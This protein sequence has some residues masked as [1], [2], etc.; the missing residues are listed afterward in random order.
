MGLREYKRELKKISGQLGMALKKLHKGF[1]RES[2]G[3]ED[4]IEKAR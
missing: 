2:A 1:G 3:H 4:K